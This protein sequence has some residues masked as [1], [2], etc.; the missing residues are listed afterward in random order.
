MKIGIVCPYNIFKPGGVQQH[1]HHQTRLLRAHGHDVTIITPR[2]ARRMEIAPEGVLFVGTS[3]RVK[4]P[5]DT[6]PDVSMADDNNVMDI[7]NEHNF[8]LI[9]IHEPMV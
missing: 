3:A 9:H 8:D 4:T 5:F 2:P 7:L 6:S 1:V